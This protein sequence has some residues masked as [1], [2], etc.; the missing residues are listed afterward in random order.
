MRS[1]GPWVVLF[2]ALA[3]CELPRPEGTFM[4]LEAAIPD[5]SIAPPLQRSDASVA[6]PPIAG[7][8]GGVAAMQGGTQGGNVG[9]GGMPGGTGD[10]GGAIGGNEVDAGG[11]LTPEELALKKLEGRYLM[12]MDMLSTAKVTQVITLA[13]RN[14]VSHL[15]ATQL[16]VEN[17]R[18]KGY[19]RLCYQTFAHTC[20]QGC[21]T[22]STTMHPV[23]TDSLV[24]MPYAERN[25]TV[26]SGMVTGLTSTMPLGF[27]ATSN[28]TMP[29]VTDNRVWDTIP[30][31]V[32]EGLLLTL[33]LAAPLKNLRCDVYTVQ[34]F[35][36]QIG[37]SKLGGTGDAPVLSGELKLATIG[38]DGTTLGSTSNDCKDDGGP[39]PTTTNEY[40]R[41]AAVRAD[42]FGGLASN[43]FWNCP[44]QTEWD[45]R[46][47]P[48]PP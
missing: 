13:T 17:G 30:G 12:R 48:P 34:N 6:A 15:I 27:D 19:E 43:D 31:G 11:P 29:T 24:K 44:P 37:P 47:P 26:S 21:T 20:T 8:I 36:S 18:L 22:L 28:P 5:S 42:E 16:A 23:V 41:Y 25:Y 32:R 7:G 46:L 35:V 10:G 2:L 3:A 40:V 33:D 4:E 38:S 9:G 14:R 45:K 39:P 1:A